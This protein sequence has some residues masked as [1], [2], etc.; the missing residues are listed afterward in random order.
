MES[1]IDIKDR[2][3]LF[4]LEQDSRQSLQQLAKKV[5]LKKETLFHRMK[6]LESRGIIKSYLTEINIY[7]L[8][9]QYY[10]ILLKLQNT[11]PKIEREIF[12]YLQ[13]STYI[14]WLTKCEGAWDITLTVIAKGNL[15]FSYFMNEFLEKYSEYIADKH[16][17]ITTE[18]HY[19]KRGFWLD[20]K[21]NSIITTGGD[22]KFDSNESDIKLLKILSTNARMP[23]VEIAKKLNT[24]PKTIAYKIKKLEKEEIIQG[25]RIL[26]DF[27][28]IGYKFYKVFFS[29]KDLNDKSFKELMKY[30]QEHQNIIWATKIIGFYD[31]SIEMEVRDVEEFRSVLNEIKNKFS[32]LIKKHESLLIF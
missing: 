19:F 23:L 22:E 7:K 1:K 12:S 31:L 29:F 32:H 3:I 4:G 18:I 13:K 14:A 8:G 21:T 25:S 15:D 27:S 30:F 5:G 16:I 11:T 20:K 2:K 9:F 28:K 17:F 10:P 24:S 26:V 6:N